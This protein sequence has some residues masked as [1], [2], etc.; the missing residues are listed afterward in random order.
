[1]FRHITIA[2]IFLINISV[3]HAEEC[4]IKVVTTIKPFKQLIDGVLGNEGG[5]KQIIKDG[6]SPHDFQLKPSDLSA[7]N[8][9]DLFFWGGENLDSPIKK[10][11][12][13][14]PPEVIVVDLSKIS[15]IELVEVEEQCCH[16]HEHEHKQDDEKNYDGHIWL[17]PKNA[18]AILKVVNRE[19]KKACPSKADIFDLNTEKSIYKLTKLD[20][21]IE[22]STNSYQDK[23]FMAFHDAFV[24]FARTYNMNYL[25]AVSKSHEHVFSAKN[26]LEIQEN[27]KQ[28]QPVCI[29][30]E[31]NANPKILNT[32]LN[33][34]PIN[35]VEIDHIGANQTDNFE[36]YITLMREVSNNITR[37]MQQN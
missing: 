19:L 14:M 6:L 18:I 5:T 21:E 9:S 20:K 23:P 16:N 36:G 30:L 11:V 8:N 10:Y 24:Y 2:L 33:G 3:V 17:S 32:I 35:V 25:G 12:D 15:G 34:N 29:I 22:Q 31:P 7:M 27:I 4:D 28:Q 26:V 37:C 1:M 13:K